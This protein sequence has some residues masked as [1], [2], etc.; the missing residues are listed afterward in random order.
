MV[1]DHSISV[2]A[3]A[4]VNLTLR[5]TG[6]KEDGYHL[7]HSVVVF[8]DF[9][10]TIILTPSH[11]FSFTQ[12]SDVSLLP[13][14]T[15]NLVYSAAQKFSSL[16][17]QSLNCNIHLIKKT[18]IG[19]GLGGGSSDVAATIKAIIK[20]WNITINETKLQN[21]LLSMGADVPVCYH[22]SS[23]LVEGVGENITPLDYSSEIYAV[24]VY[25]EKFCSTKE[26]FK[27]FNQPY[28]PVPKIPVKADFLEFIKDQKNDLTG[29]AIATIPNIA[30]VLK[31][32]ESTE[33]IMLSR[34][35]GSGSCC[36]G[37]YN[38]EQQSHEAALKIQKEKP[39][40][41]VRPVILNKQ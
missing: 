30:D 38:N 37:L 13:D 35:S 11:K 24:L 3:P 1:S 10:D 23:C 6:K 34:M 2:F 36:F 29:A 20:F 15:D 25:P 17:D 31:T 39:D 5:V 7:L 8:A 4:K 12:A 28:S 14:D 19:A 33:N 18:P 41:W 16:T 40:W 9:G 32:L 22:S 27:N 21:F 26:I